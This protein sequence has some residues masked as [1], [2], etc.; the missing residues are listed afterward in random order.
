MATKKRGRP[1]KT[2]APVNKERAASINSGKKQVWQSFGLPWLFL[3]CV[4]F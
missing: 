3:Y 4:L 1:K 2:Q